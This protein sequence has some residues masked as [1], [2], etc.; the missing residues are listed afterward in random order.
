MKTTI[1][2]NYQLTH[3][4][5]CV[6]GLILG[7]KGTIVTLDSFVDDTDLNIIV[8][9]FEWTVSRTAFAQSV[10]PTTRLTREQLLA[11]FGLLTE[12]SDRNTYAQYRG[13]VLE[14]CGIVARAECNRPKRA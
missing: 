9:G 2:N 11:N 12:L 10:K 4:W 7:L 3:D 1:G 6:N 5:Q 14:I 8:D 13:A